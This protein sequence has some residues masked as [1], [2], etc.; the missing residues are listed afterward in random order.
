[1]IWLALESIHQKEQSMRMR[2]QHN[3][4]YKR[5]QVL[6]IPTSDLDGRMG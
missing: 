4:R 6:S 5:W 2:D 1:M 3:F